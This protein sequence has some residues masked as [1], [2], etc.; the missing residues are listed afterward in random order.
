[1]I[2]TNFAAFGETSAE[3]FSKLSESIW[4]FHKD[5]VNI[6]H[7]VSRLWC[8]WWSFLD[9]FESK[10]RANY[11]VMTRNAGNVRKKFP[12][13]FKISTELKTTP[14]NNWGRFR[15]PGACL[16]NFWSPN[17]N[18]RLC[19]FFDIHIHSRAPWKNTPLICIYD[20]C[21]LDYLRQ[22]KAKTRIKIVR[23]ERLAS[24]MIWM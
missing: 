17:T 24:K 8:I 7:I 4:G 10:S 1:M 12:N 23:L 9:I 19:H 22:H 11:N 13:F 15:T 3:T 2:R 18:V 14:A 21:R 16:P 20:F 6:T 5:F